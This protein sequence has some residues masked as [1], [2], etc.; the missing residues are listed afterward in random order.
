VQGRELAVWV[1]SAKVS[2]PTIFQESAMRHAL[3]S[4]PRRLALWTAAA[5]ALLGVAGQ[6]LA[7]KT[8]LLVY[9]ALEADQIKAYKAVSKKPTPRSS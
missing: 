9:S 8:E 2:I 7:A 4:R 1:G 3:V 5:C 6:A